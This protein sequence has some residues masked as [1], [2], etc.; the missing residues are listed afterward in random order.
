M[1]RKIVFE[2]VEIYYKDRVEKYFLDGNELKEDE[3]ERGKHTYNHININNGDKCDTYA[4]DKVPI[5][6]YNSREIPLIVKVKSL[7]DAIN[8]M[9]SDFQNHMQ[10]SRNT[11]LIN[12]DGTRFR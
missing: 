8:I 2:K 5:V 11:I 4:W 10:D 1:R 7:Q 6:K 9:L 12:Y 3:I